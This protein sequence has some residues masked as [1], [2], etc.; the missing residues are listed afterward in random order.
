MVSNDDFRKK[1]SNALIQDSI[2]GGQGFLFETREVPMRLS[3]RLVPLRL[4]QQICFPYLG[5]LSAR[6]TAPASV[7]CPTARQAASA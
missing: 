3:L 5:V 7:T 4:R 2:D 6:P 1:A